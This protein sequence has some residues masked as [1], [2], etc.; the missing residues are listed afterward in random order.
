MRNKNS[1]TD[2]LQ[3]ENVKRCESKELRVFIKYSRFVLN[4]NYT[5]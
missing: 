3:V 5:E 1:V 2:L 4:N